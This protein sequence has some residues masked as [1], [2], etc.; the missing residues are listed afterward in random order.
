[1]NLT[2]E[3]VD[4]GYLKV[5]IVAQAVVAEVLSELFAVLDGL[6]VAFEV[7]PDLVSHRDAIFHVEKEF[8]HRHT[9]NRFKNRRSSARAATL[10]KGL[11]EFRTL[12]SMTV[13]RFRERPWRRKRLGIRAIRCTIWAAFHFQEPT[14]TV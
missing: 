8:L 3:R 9:S 7:D 13:E 11:P 5:F 14:R 10:G 4:D 12:A 2:S 1:M 6:P